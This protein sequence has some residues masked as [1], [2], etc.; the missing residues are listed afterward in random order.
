MEVGISVHC[1]VIIPYI[2]SFHFSRKHQLLV[3]KHAHSPTHAYT[4]TN[5]SAHTCMLTLHYMH[6]SSST[7]RKGLVRMVTGVDASDVWGPNLS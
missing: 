4:C 2:L 6:S 3:L 1:P 7:N 5:M